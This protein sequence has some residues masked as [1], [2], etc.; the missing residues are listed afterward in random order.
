MFTDYGT[1]L[2]Q[3]YLLSTY[4]VPDIMLGPA[5]TTDVGSPPYPLLFTLCNP[6][7]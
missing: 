7:P 6:F 1:T 5:D 3:Q 4:Y 2:T